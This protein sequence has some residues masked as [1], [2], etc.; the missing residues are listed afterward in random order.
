MLHKKTKHIIRY[1]LLN[2][3]LLAGVW[4][5]RKDV[6]DDFHPYPATL[7]DLQPLLEQ[8][9]GP[10]VRSTFS[11]AGLSKDTMLLSSGGVRVFLTDV[12][13]LLV[14]GN[15]QT[16]AFGTC[17]NSS[18]EIL[19][20]MK[21]GDYVAR[22]IPSTSTTGALLESAGVFRLRFFCGNEQLFL[23]P[24]RTIKIQVPENNRRDDLFVYTGVEQQNKLN[25][26]E[27]SGEPVYWADWLSVDN[28]EMILG[29]EIITNQLDWISNSRI[30]PGPYSTFCVNVPTGFSDL[31]TVVYMVYKNVK[32][33]APMVP[34]ADVQEFC[35][36]NVP[37]GYPVRLITVSK[38]G[39]LYW[40]GSKETE[41]GTNGTLDL[42]PQVV[43]EQQM[44]S[45]LK[46][47]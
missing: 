27:N 42:V 43:T 9:P 22:E 13:Q 44:L 29:Y 31:N 16:A 17:Q 35:C 5:C 12:N 24:G 7:A 1:T 36:T 8:V 26:W 28:L 37:A 10:S 33:A 11:L 30:V 14:D 2:A 3:F 34:G 46:S 18:M 23:K 21:K 41:T 45:V 40:L 20:V 39:D 32:T 6:V 47:F 15:G 19:E 4:G 38:Y 25:A